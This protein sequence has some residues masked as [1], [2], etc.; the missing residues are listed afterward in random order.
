MPWVRIDENAMDHPKFI[1]LSANAFRLWVEGMTYCQKHLTDGLIPRSAL[2]GFRYFSP[3]SMR[4]LLDSLAPGKGP[5]WHQGQNGDIEVHDYMDWNICRDTVMAKRQDGKERM[6]RIRAREHPSEH[7]SEQPRHTSC[8][9]VQ[10]DTRISQIREGGSGET[11]SR[12]KPKGHHGHVFCGRNFCL[13]NRQEDTVL[14]GLGGK[15]VKW[16]LRR[17]TECYERWDAENAEIYNLLPWLRERIQRELGVQAE[18][19]R[20]FTPREIQEFDE[21][22]RKVGGCRHEP[23]CADR[24][25]CMGV[26][27]RAR[28]GAAA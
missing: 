25:A 10:G 8:G 26:F 2:K 22:R 13:S 23:T 19:D 7:P 9:V 20:P 3:A 24:Q 11:L 27:I 4:L 28:R 12:Q 17:A 6:R 18:P 5:L 16:T 1:A 21:W 14:Q 15:K